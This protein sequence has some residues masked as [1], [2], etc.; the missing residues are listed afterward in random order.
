M[1]ESKA[2]WRAELLGEPAEFRNGVNYDKRNFGKGIKVV[3]VKD[4]QDY[5]KPRYSELE[6]INPEG[7]VTERNILRDGD[8]VFVR[9]NGNRALIGRSLYIEAP[10]ERITHSAFTIRLRFTSRDVLPQFYAHLFR[11]RLIREQLMAF[12]GGTNIS[13]LNQDIL[14]RL[15]VPLPPLPLQRR[16]AAILSAYD[17]LIENNLRRIRILE[18]IARAIY[19]EWFVY[20]RFPGH[21]N[22]PRVESLL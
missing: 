7:I 10:K 2:K 14:N 1:I 21:E 20:F 6:Q 5:S 18:E 3:G 22:V 19:R 13:N 11:T 15:E 16:I 17:D 4:F 12:G 8:I 9:S